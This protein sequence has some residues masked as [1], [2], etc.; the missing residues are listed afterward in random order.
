MF[1]FVPFGVA[2]IFGA[3]IA[4][5]RIKAWP[6]VLA[7]GLVAIGFFATLTSGEYLTGWTTLA[8]D[9]AIGMLGVI[10]GVFSA[11]MVMRMH[12]FRP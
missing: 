3:L 7:V 4:R 12:R 1:E 11:R 9:V 2:A 10:F 6:L 8:N 5:S